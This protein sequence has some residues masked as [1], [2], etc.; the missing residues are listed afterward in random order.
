MVRRGF[1]LIELLVVIAIIALVLGLLLPSLAGARRA[2]RA[3]VCL[4]NQRTIAQ[5]FHLY[6]NQNRD[7]V[8]PS[9]T[10]TGIDTTEPLEGWGPIFDR[11]GYVAA[12]GTTTRGPFVCPETIDID[13]MEFGQ[14]G[15]DPRRP[16]GWMD[17]P[18]R[19][20]GETYTATTIPERGFE[21]IIRVAY[22]M[23]AINPIGSS[24]NVTQ[25]L[26]Y[27]A[28][29]GY[30]PGA[31]GEI[32]RQMKISSFVRPDQLIGAADGVYAG[33][34]RDNKIGTPNSRIGYRHPGPGGGSANV[35]FSDGHG[36]P[37]D[38]LNFPRGWGGGNDP[39]VVRA[40]NLHGRASVFAHPEKVLG[41]N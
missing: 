34:Q 36:A 40:E 5:G 33:R 7:L 32:A 26:Y 24:V 27:T 39:E 1:S 4:G 29:V 30:G 19:K 2:G 10:M 25:D 22:W 9:Y 38:A 23:N 35:A 8:V 21:R 37:L 18:T 11:D 20:V 28:S 14:T 41:V 6:Y 31:N 16:K 12:G 3:A 13:A 15:D 17:W